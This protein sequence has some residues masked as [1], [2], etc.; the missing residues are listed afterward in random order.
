M[1]L[2]HLLFNALVLTCLAVCAHALSPFQTVAGVGGPMPGTSLSCSSVY[3]SSIT[4]TLLVSSNS[5][6]MAL[7]LMD[8]SST[9][10]VAVA[11]PAAVLI[12]SYPITVTGGATGIADLTGQNGYLLWPAD[13]RTSP[14]TATVQAPSTLQLQGGSIWQGAVYGLSDVLAGRVQACELNP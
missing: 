11:R 4:S 8:V 12:S 10:S 9:P 14:S 1:K 7:Y 13:F 3:V 2:R 5:T 6:R